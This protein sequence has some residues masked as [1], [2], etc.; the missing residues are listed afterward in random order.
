MPANISLSLDSLIVSMAIVML[1]T[2]PL[3]ALILLMAAICL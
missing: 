2:A 1:G 3:R